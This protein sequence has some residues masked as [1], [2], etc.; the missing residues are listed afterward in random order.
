MMVPLAPPPS[1]TCSPELISVAEAVPLPS[2]YWVAP[3][4]TVVEIAT[5]PRPTLSNA[6]LPLR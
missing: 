2:T 1:I 5:P 6:P 4:S 3:D